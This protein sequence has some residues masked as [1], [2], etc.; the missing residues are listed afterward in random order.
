[1]DLG[2]GT[3]NTE[4]FDETF[5][6]G[7][8]DGTR[9]MSET[10]SSCAGKIS[11]PVGTT[12]KDYENNWEKNAFAKFMRGVYDRY[13][14]KSRIDQFEEKLHIETDEFLSQVKAFLALEGKK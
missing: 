14:I 6:W 3:G 5:S 4:A 7:A 13:I 11:F 9:N 12:V 8:G 1:M 2:I 10:N